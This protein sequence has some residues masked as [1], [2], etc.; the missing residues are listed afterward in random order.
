[1]QWSGG[2]LDERQPHL[3][4]DS[5]GWRDRAVDLGQR[6]RRLGPPDPPAFRRRRHPGPRGRSARGDRKP[7]QKGRLAAASQRPSHVPG[8]VRGIWRI[9]R[10]PLSQHGARGFRLVD[11]DPTADRGGRVAADRGH[12]DADPE[13]RWRDVHNSGNSARRRSKNHDLIGN[14]RL[15]TRDSGGSHETATHAS[16]A[17]DLRRRRSG[18]SCS[19]RPLRI[20]PDRDN[21]DVRCNSRQVD[22]RGWTTDLGNATNDPGSLPTVKGTPGQVP[23]KRHAGTV[24]QRGTLYVQSQDALSIARLPMTP[25]R[26]VSWAPFGASFLERR[27]ALA[28]LPLGPFRRPSEA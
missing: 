16:E 23:A 21:D 3:R 9:V 2:A 5:E 13:P 7:G 24:R 15:R 27:A 6:R 4:V 20:G 11:A 25:R 28:M 8:A 22:Y 10:D 26:R 14:A 18:R 19:G 12:S 17:D 1:G